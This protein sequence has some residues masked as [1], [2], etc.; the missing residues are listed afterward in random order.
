MRIGFRYV[1]L[2]LLTVPCFLLGGVSYTEAQTQSIKHLDINEVAVAPN[3]DGV[4]DPAEW[5]GATQR[6]DLLQVEPSEYAPASQKTDW[7]F[8][9]DKKNLYVA[10]IAHDSDPTAIVA[11]TLRQGA[12]IEN[13]DSMYVIIDGFNNKRSGFTFGLNANGVRYDG[14]YSNGTQL[15]DEWE[16]IWRGASSITDTGWS[17]EM[18]IPFNTITFDPSS[19]SWGLN[20]WRKLPRTN[21]T[22]GWQSRGGEINPTVSGE[23]LGFSGINQGVGLDITPSLSAS[24]TKD[25]D[26]DNYDEDVNPSV[27]ISYK[28]TPSINALV[29]IN[30]DFAATEVDDRQLGV[31]RFGV[32]F[33]EKRSFF[34]TDFDIF[35]FGGITDDR[36][37]ALMGSQTRAN[38][39]PFFSRRI[40][41]SP[42]GDS[43]DIVGGG[44]LSGRLG[45]LDFGSLV[46]R[47]DDYVYLEDDTE[48]LVSASNLGVA[49]VS[50]GLF[51]ESTLGAIFTSGDPSSNNDSSTAGVDFNYR[52]TRIGNNKT[53][54][55]QVWVQKTDNENVEGDDLAYNAGI[56]LSSQE[57]LAIGAQYHEVQENF[58]PKLGFVNRKGVRAYSA[59]MEYV[60]LFDDVPFLQRME[61]KLDMERWEFLD[62]GDIQ[63]QEISLHP[64]VLENK[65]GDEGRIIVREYKETLLPG[66]QPLG[67]LGIETP[68]G[69]YNSSR[70]AIFFESSEH[71][72]FSFELRVEHGDYYQGKRSSYD[73]EVRWRP[74]KHF[75]SELALDLKDYDFDD[76]RVITR[77][78]SWKT[79]IAFNSKLSLV[80]VAQFDNLSNKLGINSR[81]RYNMSAGQDLYFVIDHLAEKLPDEHRFD[82]VETTGVVKFSYTLR[83]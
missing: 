76:V 67:R 49:R 81:L 28:L 25:Y 37:D 33:P 8:A 82:S 56:G 57:G 52:N 38:G 34:L 54:E 4:F 42:V 50:A 65:F 27:D 63:S 45:R 40:G 58:D 36:G 6:S 26:N 19:P 13:D 43:V 64:F 66:E 35:Q 24:S 5:L 21:E 61:H 32:F 3:I 62:G 20:F 23:A 68:P 22:M 59:E 17:M 11:R 31:Q 80:N 12:D 79:E 7:Y 75:F 77:Q 1:F 10:A 46:I 29:T 41:L 44:K 78:L 14:I 69:E 74:S 9:Y 18:A 70:N 15:T 55:G 53:L 72:K 60:T 47:Q 16:G 48:Y 51:G 30:T 71:R 83:Y 73:I 2:N 39:L